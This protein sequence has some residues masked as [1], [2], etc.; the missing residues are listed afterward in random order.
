MARAALWVNRSARIALPEAG[1][2][3]V[4]SFFAFYDQ[5]TAGLSGSAFEFALASFI[6]FFEYPEQP[7]GE[8]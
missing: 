3:D 1:Y 6:P 8:V 2:A 5:L 4:E 7:G